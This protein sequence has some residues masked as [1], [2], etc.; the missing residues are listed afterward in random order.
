MSRRLEKVLDPF[1]GL[2]TVAYCAVKMKRRGYSI[3]LNEQYW[4]DSKAYCK[5]AEDE[6]LMPTLFDM[7]TK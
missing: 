7:E 5:A 1:G 6:V 2:G 4:R 3:E